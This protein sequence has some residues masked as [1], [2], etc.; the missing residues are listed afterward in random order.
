M[1]NN[2]AIPPNNVAVINIAQ[3]IKSIMSSAEEA[4]LGALFINYRKVILARNALEE[5]GH[6]QLPTPMQTDNTTDLEQSPTTLQAN[7]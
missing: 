3:I 2:S 6:K 1:S 4:K 7:A 5:M